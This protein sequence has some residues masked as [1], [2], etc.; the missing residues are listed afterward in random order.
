LQERPFLPLFKILSPHGLKGNL[1]VA[2]LSFNQEILVNLKKLYLEN[3]WEE[4]LEVLQIK[5][6]PGQNIFLLTLK[7]IDHERAKELVNQTLY[8]DKAD[9]PELPQEEYYYFQLEG[10][11]VVDSQGRD[12]GKVKEVMPLGEYELL[13]IK[14]PEKREFYLPLVEEYVER[15]D[16]AQ[17]LIL[18]RDLQALVESQS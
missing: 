17:G 10:L 18:V 7:G 14:G 9:L 15:V 4:P 13:L 3:R 2:L 6:G 5:K 16:L 12:W 11:R 1:R 8:L